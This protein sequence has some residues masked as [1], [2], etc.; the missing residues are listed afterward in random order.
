MITH[1]LSDF[2]GVL[3][4]T[5]LRHI[6]L[7]DEQRIN[8]DF[9]SYIKQTQ[10]P[11]TVISSAN[12]A[13]LEAR[14]LLLCPPFLDVVSVTDRGS[15]KSDPLFYTDFCREIATQPNETLFIDDSAHKIQ[16]AQQAGLQTV[17]FHSTDQATSDIEKMLQS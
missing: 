6:Q 7:S 9:I 4:F 15:S 17:H 11:A 2:A 1:I 3:F 16:A 13:T 5:D 12:Q 8:A 14:R 10:L